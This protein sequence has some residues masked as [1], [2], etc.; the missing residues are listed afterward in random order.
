MKRPDLY[1][2]IGLTFY[3]FP[4]FAVVMKQEAVVAFAQPTMPLP[5]IDVAMFT[6]RYLPAFYLC[7]VPAL[8]FFFLSF[9]YL[10]STPFRQ[11]LLCF[12]GAFAVF[13]A[14][15]SLTWPVGDT[16]YESLSFYMGQISLIL[17]FLTS[18]IYFHFRRES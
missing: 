13:F 4:A 9:A 1:F 17:I 15:P 12:F 11:A 7:A 18:S 2:F 3:A 14:I 16:Y 10:G 5:F 8:A 6:D